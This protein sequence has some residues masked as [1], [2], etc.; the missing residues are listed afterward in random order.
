MW[1]SHRK[2]ILSWGWGLVPGSGTGDSTDGGTDSSGW[3]QERAAATMPEEKC[4]PEITAGS[5]LG[6]HAFFRLTHVPLVLGT[7]LHNATDLMVWRGSPGV[8]WGLLG[9]EGNRQV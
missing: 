2:I 9:N 4:G 1:H 5:L 3:Q 8:S 7:T 6:S